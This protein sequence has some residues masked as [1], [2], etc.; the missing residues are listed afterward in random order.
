LPRGGDRAA[1][2]RSAGPPNAGRKARA[3]GAAAFYSP[4]FAFEGGE[5][6]YIEAS[7]GYTINEAFAVSGAVGNQSVETVG[8]FAPDGE[9]YATWKVGGT[10]SVAGFGVDLRYVDTDLDGPPLLQQLGEE[11]VV[12]TIKRTL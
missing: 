8:Y 10:W 2:A 12:L 11:R 3:L 1:V 4:E 9:D 7:A 5:A 6:W